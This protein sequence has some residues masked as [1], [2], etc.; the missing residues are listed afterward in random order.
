MKIQRTVKIDPVQMSQIEQI[1]KQENR[2]VSNMIE[3]LCKEALDARQQ[4]SE[5]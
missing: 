5:G 3:C 4:I 2:T 1:A